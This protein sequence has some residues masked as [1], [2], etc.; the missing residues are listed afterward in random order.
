MF[1]TYKYS[2]Y[3]RRGEQ[4]AAGLFLILTQP[5]Y[6]STAYP[7]HR[8]VCV[9]CGADR[10]THEARQRIPQLTCKV[11]SIVARIKARLA[12]GIKRENLTNAE[13]DAWTIN[14]F[15]AGCETCATVREIKEKI[16][17]TY[18]Q[19]TRID[20]PIRAIVRHT[21]FSQCG[22]FM[23]GFARVHGHS[24]TLSGSYGADGLICSV[25]DAAYPLGLELPANLREAWN[26]GGGWNSA[27]SEAPAMR[28]WAL[29]NLAALRK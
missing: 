9:T 14:E 2:G 28:K 10:D 25:P 16:G 11:H 21:S 27:G 13:L 17:C 26:K 24:I 20:Y 7:T 19:P 8:N 22:Q 6:D 18:Y 12:A 1:I 3:N 5:K 4:V 29:A 23:M 15:E